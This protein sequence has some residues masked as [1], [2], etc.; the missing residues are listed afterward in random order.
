MNLFF[1]NSKLAFLG[2]IFLAC[3]VILPAI[4]LAADN[5]QEIL[6]Q[7][8]QDIINSSPAAKSIK[9]DTM[10]SSGKIISQDQEIAPS[11]GKNPDIVSERLKKEMEK[12]LKDAQ[13]RHSDAVKFMQDTK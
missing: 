9:I 8:Y 12:I 2:R 13:L 1:K 4:V 5:D 11:S 3:F 6:N 10:H 7:L